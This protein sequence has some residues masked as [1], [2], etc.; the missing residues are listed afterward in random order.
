MF[1]HFG[2]RSATHQ[3]LTTSRTLIET[4]RSHKTTVDNLGHQRPFISFFSFYIEVSLLGHIT[5][6]FVRVP[7]TFWYHA[8]YLERRSPVQHIIPRVDN[9][10]VKLATGIILPLTTCL[11]QQRHVLTSEEL[12][13][14]GDLLND[15]NINNFGEGLRGIS[16]PI[17]DNIQ[18]L[19]LFA[20]TSQSLCWIVANSVSV[21]FAILHGYLRFKHL[22]FD[23]ELFGYTVLRVIRLDRDNNNPVSGGLHH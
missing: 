14:V 17:R 23:P 16:I 6:D 19:H 5:P 1:S 4:K 21:A 12:H 11:K 9:T 2:K 10:I 18:G 15:S 3:Q 7:I 8:H 22:D 13:L 20:L